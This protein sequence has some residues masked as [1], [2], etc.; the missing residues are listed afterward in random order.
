MQVLAPPVGNIFSDA[1]NDEPKPITA[2]FSLLAEPP[3]DGQQYKSNC[4]P[5]YPPPH[6]RG[7]RGETAPEC[8]V[9][10]V[11]ASAVTR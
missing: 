2:T 1:A 8:H 9:L 11:P 6:P 5:F 3:K 4:T 7:G 10:P